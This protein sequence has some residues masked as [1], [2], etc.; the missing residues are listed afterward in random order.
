MK[1]I[2]TSVRESRSRL[3]G[4]IEELLN[5]KSKSISQ[6]HLAKKI[7]ISASQLFNI[8]NPLK[9]DKISDQLWDS[10]STYFQR[11]N[12]WK[13]IETTNYRIIRSLCKDSQTHQ[14]LLCVIGKS[15][16][17]K[18]TA[19]KAYANSNPNAFY[20]LTDYLQKNKDFFRSIA[21]SLGIEVTG[22][23]RNMLQM[24]IEKVY[25]LKKPLIIFDDAGKMNDGNYKN[26]QLLFDATEG[27]LGIVIAGVH[28][29]KDY[30]LKMALK[31]KMGFDEFK[32][33]VE[34]WQHLSEPRHEEVE[35]LCELQG[36]KT[37]DNVNYLFN[38]INDFGTMKSVI[39][40]A[41][42]HGETVTPDILASMKP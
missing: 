7:G 9:W 31:G 12:E 42:R 10:V 32:R 23:A 28:N 22:N 15:G 34:Y 14:R 29:L 5:D 24:I 38:S 6:N 11:S 41:K 2:S 33:R 16:L 3:L 39:V 8:R 37:K 26:I 35:L 27:K 13:T 18:T 20:V 25:T 30:V 17:G 40:C 1:S 4:D 19:L 36:I 21:N